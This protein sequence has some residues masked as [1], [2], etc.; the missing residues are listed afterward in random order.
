MLSSER[1]LQDGH[2]VRAQNEAE[3]RERHVQELLSKL[4][5][6]EASEDLEGP[7]QD[8]ETIKIE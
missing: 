5:L 7:Q 6:R 8:V 4:L 2:Q 3:L 1:Q